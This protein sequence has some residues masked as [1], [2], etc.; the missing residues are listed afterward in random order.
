MAISREA[1]RLKN[2]FQRMAGRIT[3]TFQL[4]AGYGIAD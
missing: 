3:F 1:Y 2:Q 4:R